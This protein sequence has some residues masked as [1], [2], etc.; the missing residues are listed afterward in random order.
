MTKKQK[1]VL[2]LIVG[3]LLSFIPVPTVIVPEWKVRVVDENGKP[4]KKQIVRQICY[5]YTLG[6]SPCDSKDSLKKT[7]NNG[8]VSFPERKIWMSF[9][10]RIIRSFFNYLMLIAH[11]SVGTDIYLDSSGPNGLK[12]SEYDS[13]K[14]LPKDFVLSSKSINN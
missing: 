13:W 12:T 14:P 2:I 6:V 5:N 9:S 8:Y 11:G 4:Y 10:M 3:L 7:D 1:F